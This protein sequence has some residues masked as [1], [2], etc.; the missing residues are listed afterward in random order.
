MRSGYKILPDSTLESTMGTIARDD[1]NMNA[2]KAGKFS[3][4]NKNLK[5]RL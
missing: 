1:N 2:S 4:E 5:G 3:G